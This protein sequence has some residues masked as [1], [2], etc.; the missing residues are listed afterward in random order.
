[1]GVAL[2]DKVEDE[3]EILGVMR[4]GKIS[5]TMDGVKE[6]GR[7]INAAWVRNKDL[8]WSKIDVIIEGPAPR[9]YGR[10]NQVALLKIWW[11]IYHLL[12]YFYKKSRSVQVIDSFLWNIKKV[13]GKMMG[14]WN[15]HEKLEHFKLAFPGFSKGR[16]KTSEWGSKDT[17]DAALMGYWWYNY[18]PK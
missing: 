2:M 16:K 8:D 6:A 13:D 12:E 18:D 15:D 3:V 17:R 10:A 14:Q 11:Q 7:L 1:M 5:W 9:Y 4:L